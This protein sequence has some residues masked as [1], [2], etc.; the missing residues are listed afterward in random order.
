PADA[1]GGR[2]DDPPAVHDNSGDARPA[3]RTVKVGGANQPPVASFTASCAGLAC[4]FTGASGDPGGSVVAWSWDFGD[5]TKSTAQNPTHTYGSNG[6]RTVKLTV[7]DN[8]GATGAASLSVTV[9]NQAPTAAFTR[10]C[11]GL[12]CTLTSTSTDA[13]GTIA[14]WSWNFGDGKTS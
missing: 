6:T 9:S 13:D 8:A 5:G 2:S 12:A 3:E 4:A 10:S 7:T 1:A 14:S 11:T